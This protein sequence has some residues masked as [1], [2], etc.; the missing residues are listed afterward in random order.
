MIFLRC[1]KV[2]EGGLNKSEMSYIFLLNKKWIQK[3]RRTR[4]NS[5][6]DLTERRTTEYPGWSSSTNHAREGMSVGLESVGNKDQA[7]ASRPTFHEREEEEICC[8]NNFLFRKIGF[9]FHRH[10]CL[11]MPSLP[12]PSCDSLHLR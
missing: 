5:G 6:E 9:F 2:C 11:F 12:L 7:H 8:N 10:S 1:V 3:R 4:G